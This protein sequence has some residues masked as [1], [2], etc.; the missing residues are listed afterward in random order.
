MTDRELIRGLQR[1]EA[2]ALEALMDRYLPYVS[3]VVWGV[4]G[5]ALPR[6]DAEEAVS[7]AFVAAWE[8]PE[9]L[10]LG[11]IKAWLGA[12]ARNG[13]RNRLRAAGRTLP[14]DE[15]VLTLSAPGPEGEAAMAELKAFL[16]RAV[17]T[18]G[19]PD[20]EIFVR[21]YYYNQ[22]VAAVAAAVNL[23]PNTVKT[24][25]AR[26]R[27]RLKQELRRGGYDVDTALD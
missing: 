20:R 24:R 10:R 16:R 3:A 25:L 19:H 6:E 18:L 1:R 7:D 13:A 4:L 22:P 5:D 23:P 15:D 21:Y 26:G 11:H 8:H 12:V 17:E 27:A 2:E 14:M 9:C